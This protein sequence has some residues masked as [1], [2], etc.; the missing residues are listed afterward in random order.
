MTPAVVTLRRDWRAR[1]AVRALRQ[2]GPDADS[3]YYLYVTDNDGVLQGVVGLRDL[4]VAL[5]ETTI[6]ALMDP[7]VISVPVLADQEVC[8]RTLSRYGFLVLPV[9]DDGRRLVG[10]ITA[11]DL[12]EVAEDEATEDMYRMVGIRGEER[13]FGPLLPSV[14]KRL[15]WLAVN[16]ATLFVAIT[17][18]NAFESVIAG[19]VALATFLPLVSGEGGNAGSQ[20]TTVIVRGMAMGEVTVRNGLRVLAKELAAAVITGTIIGLGTA[21]VIYLWKQDLVIALAA[22][23]AMVLNFLMGALAGVLVPLGLKLM[24]VDPA[25]ASAAFVTAVTDTL[26]FL[27]FLG[28][29]TLLMQWL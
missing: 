13:V 16:M 2:V 12:I 24:Q 6:E 28:I 9:V 20:T 8:A 18:V 23:L 4:V 29:A 10:V 1:E 19:T 26:G 5:P 22:L 17:V 3:A 14:V 15:P 27:F 7:N 21:L 25:L 11:D